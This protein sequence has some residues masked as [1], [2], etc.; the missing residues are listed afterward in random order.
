MWHPV[1]MIVHYYHAYLVGEWRP[2]LV[3]H[4]DVLVD[5][6]LSERLDRPLQ[7]GLV[8]P[9]ELRRQAAETCAGRVP[10]EV[11]AEADKGWEQV[12]LGVLHAAAA[13]FD[14]A[15]GVLY[16][17]TKGVSNGRC[18][19]WRENITR[20]VVAGWRECVRQL[21]EHE[22]V[23]CYWL[24]RTVGS[25]FAGNFWWARASLLRRMAPPGNSYRLLAESWMNTAFPD[26]Y[27]M[28]AGWPL[29]FYDGEPPEQRS[30]GL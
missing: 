9:A 15:D 27:D 20:G 6:G 2:V 24:P 13:T 4:L 23:G 29:E 7:L 8:G 25:F 21:S 26:V 11:V 5:S 28:A 3:R 14:P 18:D 12:T 30:V 19:V 22:A 10:T 17:H 1:R 16:A